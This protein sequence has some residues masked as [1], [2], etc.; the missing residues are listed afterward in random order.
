VNLYYGC[1][2]DTTNNKTVAMEKSTAFLSGQCVYIF[3][4]NVTLFYIVKIL[5]QI[6]FFCTHPNESIFFSKFSIRLFLSLLDVQSS[7]TYPSSTSQT[8]VPQIYVLFQILKYW[9]PMTSLP[10]ASNDVILVKILS[11][12]IFFCTHPNESIF[13]SKFSIR[14]FFFSKKP[15]PPLSG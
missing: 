10:Y 6:I 7:N 4:L 1:D 13:F 5:S 15:C 8:S 14:L 9:R 11:Q 2:S 3:F 12:I